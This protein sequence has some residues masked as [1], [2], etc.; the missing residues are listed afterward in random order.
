MKLALD[1]A[2][3]TSAPIEASF[4]SAANA[5]YRYLE[6][7]NRD[8]VI[9]AFVPVAASSR[10]LAG[11]RRT[12][13]QAGVEIVSVAI[14]Q[15]WSSPDPDVR[16]AA[17]AWWRDGIMA[18]AEL[19]CDRVATRL[20]GDPARPGESRD[21]LLRSIDELLPSLEGAGIVVAIE[22]HPGDFIETTD[23]AIDLLRTLDLPQVRY[24]HC[25]PHA[26][27]LGG[28][29]AD[30]IESA[31]GWFDHVHVADTYR[32]DR[33][34]IDP[35]VLAARVHQH[36]DIGVGELAWDAIV[37]SLREVDFDGIATV[38]VFGWE[39]QAERSFRRNRTAL[40]QML[41]DPVGVMD[42]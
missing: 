36:S 23:A 33:T 27:Y 42:R 13:G 15:A 16:S 38:Q 9:G 22:P 7:G 25:L 19:G 29:V 3:L 12:A 8:D 2:M 37:R 34:I 39:E 4:R 20:S 26:F 6:L 28:S 41:G 32:P 18:A 14:V 10:Q 24:L 1:P 35:P 31:R 17:V 5:G 11:I 30:Q 40:S 21:A